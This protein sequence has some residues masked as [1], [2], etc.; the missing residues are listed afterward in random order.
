M[1]P[2][3]SFMSNDWVCQKPTTN[4]HSACTALRQQLS[5]VLTGRIQA[6]SRVIGR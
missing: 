4:F 3:P 5:R 1:R 2:F 6:L